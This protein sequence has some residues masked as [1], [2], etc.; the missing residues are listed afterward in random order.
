MTAQQDLDTFLDRFTPEVAAQAR[1]VLAGLRARLPGAVQLVYD[2]YNALAIG[3]A[4]VRKPSTAVIS[5]AVYPRTVLLYFL[6]GA[7][8][9]DPQGL[10]KGAGTTGR[11]IPDAGAALFADRHVSAL[12]D[13]A[14]VRAEPPFDPKGPGE[15]VIQSISAKQRP[16][17]PAGK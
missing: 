14:V 3:F 6:K 12:I 17:R 2:N 13:A 1:D 16:R 9:P 8:L 15:L 5:V 4:P 7:G 11:H 10:L